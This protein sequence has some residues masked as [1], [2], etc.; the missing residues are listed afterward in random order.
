MDKKRSYRTR[1]VTSMVLT[2][3]MLMTMIPQMAFAESSAPSVK[4]G[5]F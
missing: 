3:M 5:G 4:W 1:L 2:L